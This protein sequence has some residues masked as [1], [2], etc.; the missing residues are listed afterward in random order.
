MVLFLD[1]PPLM[2][3]RTASASQSLDVLYAQAADAARLG[4]RSLFFA[5]R[6]VAPETARSAHAVYWFCSYTRDLGR[7]SSTLEQGHA[8]LDE[9]SGMVAAGL[10]GKLVRHPV[11][12]AF[13]DTVERRGIPLD[14]PMELIEGA[15]MDLSQTRY[16]S[17][18]QLGGH[19]RRTGGMV[20]LMMMHV[21]GF[22]GPAPDY[23][24]D[25][26]LA[27]ELT[28]QLR[29][30]GRHMDQGRLFLPLEEMRAFAYSEDDLRA[31]ARNQAFHNLMRHQTE[32]LHDY[33]QRALPGLALLDPR[34]RFAAQVA[35]DL[36]RR[37]L[38]RIESSGF[39]VFQ[40]RPAVPAVERYWITARSMAG[41]ITRRL[42][43]GMSA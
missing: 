23:M 36:Y 26:G 8:N 22:R 13:F 9:W 21:L 14:Y 15:R 30:L 34:G 31:R 39:D 6:F 42:W 12:E 18:S 25:L 41:P 24:S 29:D 16:E 28:T 37:T 1:E 32:R 20:S 4:S 7:L 17:F 38:Q 11:L 40:R 2:S 10:A 5:S 19:A 3:L 35:Y 27:V 33:Y 43:K